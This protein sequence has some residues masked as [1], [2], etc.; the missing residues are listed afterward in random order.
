MIEEAG[1]RYPSLDFRVGD[2]LDLK[3]DSGVLG[4]VVALY[5]IIHLQRDQLSTAFREASRVLRPGGL[6]IISLSQRPR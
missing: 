6:A 3:V 2:M 5:S 1:R 4:G